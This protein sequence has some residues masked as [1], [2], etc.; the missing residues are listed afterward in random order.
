MPRSMRARPDNATNASTMEVVGAKIQKHS[1]LGPKGSW[2]CPSP[3]GDVMQ[4]KSFGCNRARCHAMELPHAPPRA[5]SM[6]LQGK[7]V[8]IGILQSHLGI[9][10]SGGGKANPR[11]K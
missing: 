8:P 3:A 9:E 6:G 2:R 4:S 1:W 5:A 11:S 10:L 7:P